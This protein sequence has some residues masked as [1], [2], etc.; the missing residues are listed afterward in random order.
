[1]ID[2]A[3]CRIAEVNEVLI[4]HSYIYIV[5]IW[6]R[7]S[8]KEILMLLLSLAAGPF[9]PPSISQLCPGRKFLCFAAEIVAQAIND[10]PVVTADWDR[11]FL[12]R[13]VTISA[14]ISLLWELAGR[15]GRNLIS[16]K[17]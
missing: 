6:V 12:S 2:S 14:D 15:V 4:P 3:D 5:Q 11:L 10:N 1:M 7:H 9:G 13:A 8:Y 17:N 16:V